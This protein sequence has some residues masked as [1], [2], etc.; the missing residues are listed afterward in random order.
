M[1]GQLSANR[2]CE[3]QLPRVSEGDSGGRKETDAQIMAER[4][5][6]PAQDLDAWEASASLAL[7]DHRVADCSGARH[8]PLGQAGDGPSS[9]QI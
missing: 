5:R 2:P 1:W 8:L 9:T 7:T 3:S 4:S 6:N